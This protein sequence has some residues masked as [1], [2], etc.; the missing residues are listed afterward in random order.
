M[1]GE[2]DVCAVGPPGTASQFLVPDDELQD[3]THFFSRPTL[4]SRGPLLAGTGNLYTFLATWNTF[5][6]EVPFWADRLRGVRGIRG[7]LV[8]TVEHNCNP[9][10]QG[11]LVACFQYGDNQFQRGNKPSMCTHLPHV[12]L[13]VADNTSA[14]LKVPYLE[15][16][17]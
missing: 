5:V 13:N 14:T 7:D 9:F 8:F 6:A 15:A 10:H 3:L 4:I 17:S 2:A 1:H 16:L 11:L 12:R